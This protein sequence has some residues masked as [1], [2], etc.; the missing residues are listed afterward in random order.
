MTLSLVHIASEHQFE[1]ARNSSN[2]WLETGRLSPYQVTEGTWCL[3][4]LHLSTTQP[5]SGPP[6]FNQGFQLLCYGALSGN[7]KPLSVCQFSLKAFERGGNCIVFE[8]RPTLLNNASDKLFFQ[9]LTLSGEP[10]DLGEKGEV[11]LG[12]ALQR[13]K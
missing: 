7:N 13:L 11:L 4:P 9:L 6:P 10:A 12:V 1:I 8:P 2:F 3:V 5:L